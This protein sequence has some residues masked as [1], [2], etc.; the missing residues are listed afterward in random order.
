MAAHNLGYTLDVRL[1]V[2]SDEVAMNVYRKLFPSARTYCS[3][4]D[5]ILDGEIPA[6]QSP[7]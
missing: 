5:D 6:L 7:T 4:I 3:P 2:D 1:A